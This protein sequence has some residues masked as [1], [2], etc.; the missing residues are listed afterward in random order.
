MMVVFW[1]EH[2]DGI[3][4]RLDHDD[5]YVQEFEYGLPG[6][7][8]EHLAFLGCVCLESIIPMTQ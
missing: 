5:K 8:V 3:F 4:C 1:Q 2:H 7:F 6:F